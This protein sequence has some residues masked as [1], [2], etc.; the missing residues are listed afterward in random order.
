VSP[1]TR[2]GLAPTGDTRAIKRAYAR[3]LKATRPEDDPAGFQALREAY[4]WALQAAPHFAG[5]GGDDAD[6]A[7]ATAVVVEDAPQA[8]DTP[9]AQPAIQLVTEPVPQP[10]LPQPMDEARRIWA[11]YVGGAAVQ[12]R[13][14]LQRFMAREDMLDMRVR[15]CVELCA[16][17][18]C[19]DADCP[20]TVRAALIAW[21]GWEQDSSFVARHRPQQAYEALA[22]WR[23][24]R[25]YD[26]GRQGA[27]GAAGHGCR[28]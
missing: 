25:S 22:R 2:L 9:A 5:D 12:P 28:P 3:L 17:E 11:E 7:G 26:G 18:Y 4:E 8:E 21:Y 19:A 10:A 13:Q 24:D 15:E 14:R 27:A 1:W 20:D 23:A 6:D 16:V